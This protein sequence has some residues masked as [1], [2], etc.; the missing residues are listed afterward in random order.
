MDGL[1]PE[2]AAGAVDGGSDLET[3][4]GTYLAGVSVQSCALLDPA[5]RSASDP[6][7]SDGSGIVSIS[8]PGDFTGFLRLEGPVGAAPGVPV[9][10]YPG[11]LLASDTGMRLPA[12]EISQDEM[13][14][15]ASTVT[16]T[17]VSLD[18]NGTV[19]HVLVN[20]YD[21]QDHQAPGVAI[22]YATTGA[23]TE[24][25]YMSG[26]VPDPRATQ[27]DSFGLGGAINVPIG[28]QTVRATL[29]DGGAPLG[30]TTITVRAGQITWAWVRVRAR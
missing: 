11:R 22:Q 26:G 3:V 17:P 23:D 5:C 16:A 18:P 19:G 27:T 25:F 20:V 28:T 21:C 9:S 30:S 7:S 13:R 2:L 8:V 10:L 15:L 24:D 12:Y 6:V 29:A 4:R 14:I 1:Q